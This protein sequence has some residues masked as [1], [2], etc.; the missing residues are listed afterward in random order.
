MTS[1]RRLR[2]AYPF[3]SLVCVLS[4]LLGSM[5]SP[6]GKLD[7]GAHSAEAAVP[8]PKAS[9]TVNPTTPV[10]PSITPTL[11]PIATLTPLMPRATSTPTATPVATPTP[12]AVALPTVAPAPTATPTIT[13]SG[14][15][16]DTDEI[17]IDPDRDGTLRS[18]DGKVSVRFPAGV[19]KERLRASF[20]PLDARVP[21]DR[22]I[23]HRFELDARAIDRGDAHV[24]HF[25]KDVQI[26]IAYTDDEMKGLN[27]E[28]LRLYFLDEASHQWTIVPAQVDLVARTLTATV[29]HF[30]QYTTQTDPNISAPGLILGFQNDLHSGTAT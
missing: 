28:A 1:N 3:L 22:T 21:A 5:P 13:G 25:D 2:L 16:T 6:S 30:S 4:L 27:P 23:V 17:E 12:V 18:R 7:T 14:A 24:R 11:L 8:S 15:P 10:K 19:S 29:N 20:K 26:T 9:A